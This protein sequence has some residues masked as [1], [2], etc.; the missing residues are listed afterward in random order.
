MTYSR[1]G[2]HENVNFVAGV[3]R[4]ENGSLMELAGICTVLDHVSHT[5]VS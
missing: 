2:F 5:L 4:N 3:D 1:V